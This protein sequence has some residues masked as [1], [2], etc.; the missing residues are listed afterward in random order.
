MFPG[1]PLIETEHLIKRYGEK[2]A[3]DDVSFSVS[4]GEIFGFLGPN[5]AGKTTTIKI[6]VGLL[7]PTSGVVKVAGYDVLRQPLQAKAACGYVPDEP[8]LY[9]K[10][11]PRELL[12]FVGDLYGL[13]SSLVTRRSEELLRLFGLSEAAN[14][15][16]DSYSHG[17]KQKTS[18]AAALVHDPRVLILD[19]PTVGLDPRSARLIKDILRQMADRGAAVM[20]STHILEIAQAM[21]D[22]IGIIN[23]GKLIAVGTM[24]ELRQLGK[25]ESSLEDIFLSLTGGVEYA[26]IAEV[27][28]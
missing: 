13:E 6:L 10:L 11:T 3:V 15:T 24:E 19:E 5:G 8:N 1:H 4:G 25:G 18:L 12:R 28:Q 26:E 22:R 17:M 20:L 27:L 14:D 23:Q 16:I 2:T 7:Q 21:C 9:P